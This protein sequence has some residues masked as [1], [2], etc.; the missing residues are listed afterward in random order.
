MFHSEKY[1]ISDFAVWR[2][3]SRPPLWSSGQSSW[4]YN[5]DVLFLVRYDLNLC[6]LCRGKCGRSV[7]IDRS[8]T[9]TI[10]FFFFFVGES[11]PLL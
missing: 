5:G 6:M 7:G 4:L 3:E 8:R 1:A 9:Q 2:S 11:R 10:E